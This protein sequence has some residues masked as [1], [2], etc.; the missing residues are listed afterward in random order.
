MG[1]R[2][3]STCQ[4]QERG[5]M[6]NSFNVPNKAPLFDNVAVDSVQRQDTGVVL[7]SKHNSTLSVARRRARLD[8]THGTHQSP[9]T[10]LRDTFKGDSTGNILVNALCDVDIVAKDDIHNLLDLKS[11]NESLEDEVRLGT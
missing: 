11:V 8:D 7:D 1:Y 3:Q 10:L 6:S 4:N 5:V 9:Q 2:R